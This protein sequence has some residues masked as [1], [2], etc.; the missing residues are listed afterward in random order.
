[1]Y[2]RLYCELC[3]GRF[4]LSRAF[5]LAQILALVASDEKMRDAAPAPLSLSKRLPKI[6]ALTVKWQRNLLME[7]HFLHPA[8]Y[9]AGNQNALLAVL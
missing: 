9:S 1:M 4:M 8:F 5:P 2:N 3:H 6:H 7:R